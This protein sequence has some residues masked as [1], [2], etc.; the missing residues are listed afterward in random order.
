MF[1]IHV[2]RQERPV[3]PVCQFVQIVSSMFGLVIHVPMSIQGEWQHEK[4]SSCFE[5]CSKKFPRKNNV[6]LKLLG[7]IGWT[8][9]RCLAFS[10]NFVSLHISWQPLSSGAKLLNPQ[11]TL[12]LALILTI[13]MQLIGEEIRPNIEY[14]GIS[15]PLSLSHAST[16]TQ[17]QAIEA[18]VSKFAKMKKCKNAKYLLPILLQAGLAGEVAG[19]VDGLQLSEDATTGQDVHPANTS[20]SLEN[21]EFVLLLSQTNQLHSSNAVHFFCQHNMAPP[22]LSLSHCQLRSVRVGPVRSSTH[23][24]VST[25]QRAAFKSGQE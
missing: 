19:V 15:R 21:C 8:A 7:R 4:F 11:T 13:K 2:C 20:P 14:A 18:P 24:A 16:L 5:G 6:L 12:K 3:S 25:N 10:K 1:Y 9:N 23:R 22:S 17:L